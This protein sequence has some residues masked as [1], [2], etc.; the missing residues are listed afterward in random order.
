MEV[1]DWQMLEIQTWAQ[2]RLIVA[3]CGD[4]KSLW[5]HQVVKAW[6]SSVPPGQM[7]FPGHRSGAVIVLTQEGQFMEKGLRGGHC[8][9]W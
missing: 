5:Y 1:I 7:I 3:V 4:G 6:L 9:M 2:V 8:L